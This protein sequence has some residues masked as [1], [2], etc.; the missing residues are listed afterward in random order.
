GK[1]LLST[2]VQACRCFHHLSVCTTPLCTAALHGEGVLARCSGREVYYRTSASWTAPRPR[3]SFLWTRR[4]CPTSFIAPRR[5]LLASERASI[6]KRP[7][8]VVAVLILCAG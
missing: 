5:G 1:S 3:N 7:A 4:R 2:C 8:L 6:S